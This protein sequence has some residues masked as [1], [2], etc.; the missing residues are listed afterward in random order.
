[1]KDTAQDEAMLA[2]DPAEI[3]VA[4]PVLNE[5]RH[6]AATLD[7]LMQDTAM[8]RQVSIVVADGGSTDR[9]VEIVQDMARRH[10]NIRLVHNPLRL[11]SAAINLVVDTCAEPR[12]TI[13]VRVDAHSVYPGDYV[14]R[15]ANSLRGKG[16]EALATVMD[17][18]GTSCFQ[19]GAAWATETKAGSGGSAHRGGTVSGLVDHGHHAGFDLATFRR[20]GGY[21]PRFVANEDAELDHRISLAGGRI[22]LDA[23]IRLDYVMRPTL[24]GLA[25]QYWRYG[26][27]RAQT[28]LTHRMR[29]RPRQ[30]IPPAV[31][32]AA[33][34][35]LVLGP[36]FPLALT[37]P[38]AYLGLVAS[39]TLIILARHRSLCAVWAL[40]ALCAM[41]FGW[42]LGFLAELTR[43]AA[44]RT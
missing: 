18:V 39:V 21:N 17:S 41:H 3:L 1:M 13:L 28:M 33:V 31:V 11:Q 30:V 32:L 9:T 5:E 34:L 4:I 23:T 42:G 38:A 43:G 36:I 2:V 26:R 44:P 6:I 27:G 22:W 8:M 12:H 20:V 16:V 40:P 29:P 35:G 15:V 14:L 10:P 19:K 24:R 37:L 25:R 7:A